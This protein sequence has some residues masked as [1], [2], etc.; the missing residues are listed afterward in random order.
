MQKKLE[1]A[2]NKQQ[3]TTLETQ[4]SEKRLKDAIENVLQATAE[5]DSN[6]DELATVESELG[7]YRAVLCDSGICELPA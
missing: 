3:L 2:R 1:L 4:N 5:L 6:L 7:L